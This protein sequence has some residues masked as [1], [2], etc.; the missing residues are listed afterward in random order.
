MAICGDVASFLLRC[1]H[2]PY[3][4]YAIDS[5]LVSLASL[6]IRTLDLIPCYY[7]NE[8]NEAINLTS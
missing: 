7:F 4:Y 6:G 1:V 8:A 3:A 5:L 2:Y